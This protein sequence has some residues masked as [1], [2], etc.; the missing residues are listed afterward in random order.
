MRANSRE[1]LIEWEGG[2]VS[3]QPEKNLDGCVETLKD[4]IKE[5]NQVNRKKLDDTTLVPLDE[6]RIGFTGSI[7]T[8]KDNWITLDEVIDT[9][10]KIRARPYWSHLKTEVPVMKYEDSLDSIQTITLLKESYHCFVIFKYDTGVIYIADGNDHFY[11]ESK[12]REQ[13]LLKFSPSDIVIPLQTRFSAKQDL[14]GIAACLIA[15]QFGYFIEKGR[16]EDLAPSQ[17]LR[18][19]ITN[20]LQNRNSKGCIEQ[21]TTALKASLECKYCHK[22]FKNGSSK[23]LVMHVKMEHRNMN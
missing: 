11:H 19:T 5:Y 3:W 14:C 7:I 2:E 1:F 4:F 6:Q 15:L 21:Q 22:K 12:V 17:Y 10:Y 9:V 8:A 16:F 20:L 23:K 18:N 13:I